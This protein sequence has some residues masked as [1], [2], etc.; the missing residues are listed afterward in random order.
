MDSLD[1]LKSKVIDGL[2]AAREHEHI[3]DLQVAVEQWTNTNM[4]SVFVFTNSFEGQTSGQRQVRV[5][6]WLEN[7][8]DDERN[9]IAT[10]LLRT[11]D[12]IKRQA[13]G[14]NL[15]SSGAI[16]DLD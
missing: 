15:P 8:S 16:L 2:K 14:R 13:E 12:E 4:V 7:L 5:L 10:F 6:N 1:T 11:Q 9:R 3:D